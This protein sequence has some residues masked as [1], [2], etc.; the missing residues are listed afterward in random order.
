MSFTRCDPGETVKVERK[1]LKKA[2]GEDEQKRVE[3]TSLS[4]KVDLD[5]MEDLDKCEDLWQEYNNAVA[6]AKKKQRPWRDC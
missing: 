3:V 2:T 4:A 6:G 1:V 5:K